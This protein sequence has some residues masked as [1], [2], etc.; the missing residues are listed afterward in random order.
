[1]SLE[2]G[3]PL[4]LVALLAVP[5]VVLVLRRAHAVRRRADMMV[6]GDDWQRLGRSRRREQLRAVLLLA[7]LACAALALARPQ[8]GSE[9]SP[10]VRA[11]IDV[12]IAL[13]ISRSME[14][15]DVEPSRAVGAAR[16]LDELLVHLRGDRAGLVTFAGD[17]FVRSPLTLD[18][19]AVRVLVSRAQ[20][21]QSLVAPGTNLAAAIDR[22]LALLA[23]TPNPARTQ[24][25]V[26]ISDGEQLA[27]GLE[28][29]TAEA[30]SRGVRIYTVA[31]GT[32]AGAPVPSRDVLA[33]DDALR[34]EV[35]RADRD[36]LSAVAGATG[37][38]L[39]EI[40][41]LPGL[42]VVFGRLAQTQ[43]D[44]DEVRVPIERFQWFAGAALA[45][46]LAETLVAPASRLAR[47]GPRTL[48]RRRRPGWRRPGWLRRR[49]TG[50]VAGSLLVA[51]LVACGG[52]VAYH[53][54]T[55]GNA[56]YQ[57]GRF[58]AALT[59]YRDATEALDGA[60]QDAIA[61]R[62]NTGNALHQLE[63][64]DAALAASEEAVL[65]EDAELA[66]FA[67]YA[68]GS[69]AYALNDLARARQA[70]IDVLMLDPTDADAKHNLE[71]V[72]RAL[73]PPPDDPA[74]PDPQEGSEGGEEPDGEPGASTP[75]DGGNA[76]PEDDPGSQP[77]AQ[78]GASP[79]PGGP[80]AT[81][82]A[83]P[84][85]AP[86]GSGGSP[87]DVTAPGGASG[88]PQT[89]EEAVAALQEALAMQDGGP[90]TAEQALQ[91]L[92]LLRQVTGLESLQQPR[93]GGGGPADR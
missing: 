20:R 82:E 92:D 51:L 67:L 11:G 73:Q 44:E 46:M 69:H 1:M 42:A 5:L 85:P 56:E 4:G 30:A 72:L 75:E 60:S 84:S 93:F 78:P 41:A 49:E 80:G 50:P 87:P 58:E 90:L 27:S 25:I 40:E 18:V 21:E 16:A 71:L 28:G 77:G 10:V 88:E 29:A 81:P 61:V 8:W 62:Y 39:R 3:F 43:F 17:A 64:F 19:D 32:A 12:V 83:G 45:L 74:A 66:R 65:A 91:L 59:A 22:A 2:F 14:A 57:T 55:R 26:L 13:D 79:T 52:S 37:G 24:V 36:T 48:R 6:G 38:E 15:T 35:T 89:L 23:T 7:A 53:A 70:L 9:E 54:V 33:G 68:V 34:G 47:R 76:D 63:R 86:D 31:A